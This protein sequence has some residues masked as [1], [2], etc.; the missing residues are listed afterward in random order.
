MVLNDPGTCESKEQKAYWRANSHALSQD[1]LKGV[2]VQRKDKAH[3]L[4]CA[5]NLCAAVKAVRQIELL[6]LSGKSAANLPIIKRLLFHTTT[7]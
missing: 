4:A 1:F 6:P 2:L 5:Q 3:A 7:V